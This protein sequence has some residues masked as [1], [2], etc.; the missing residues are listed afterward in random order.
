MTHSAQLIA[1]IR[2]LIGYIGEQ[3]PNWWS[4]Q[5]FSPNATAFLAPVFTR[6]MFSAQCQGVCEAAAR[7]HDEHIGVGRTLHLFRLPEVFEQSV[8]DALADA[9]FEEQI[10]PHL[11]GREQ[12]M[13]RLSELASPA[14]AND[15]PMVVGDFNEALGPALATIAG[16]YLDAFRKG[17]KTFPYLREA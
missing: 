13:A 3:V 1:E 15:G 11:T 2:A 17:I 12:A 4:S 10:R 5:F 16:L 9:R 7:C 8:A 14:P 6:S